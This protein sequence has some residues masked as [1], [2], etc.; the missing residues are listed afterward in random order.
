MDK[1]VIY[2]RGGDQGMT[3]LLDGT[4]VK[5]MILVWKATEQLMN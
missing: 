1:A 4:R 2:T 3:S 5:N